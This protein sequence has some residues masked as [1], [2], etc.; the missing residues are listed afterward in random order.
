MR[1]ETSTESSIDQVEPYRS[2]VD[3]AGAAGTTSAMKSPI[4]WIGVVAVIAIGTAGVFAMMAP[5]VDDFGGNRAGPPQMEDPIGD[6]GGIRRSVPY[7]I[8]EDLAQQSSVSEANAS[9]PQP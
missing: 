5:V 9:V 4:L 6:Y 2:P 1:D 8:P 7:E 3:V